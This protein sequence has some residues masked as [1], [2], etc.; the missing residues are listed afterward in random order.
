MRVIEMCRAQLSFGDGLIAEEVSDLREHWMETAARVLA[1]TLI[2]DLIVFVDPGSKP[3][4]KSSYHYHNCPHRY[5]TQHHRR[6]PQRSPNFY[7]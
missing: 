1:P 2:L 7:L 6:N 5:P 3:K 4:H